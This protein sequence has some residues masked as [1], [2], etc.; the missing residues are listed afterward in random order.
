MWYIYTFI[1]IFLC[2]VVLYFLLKLGT[3]NENTNMNGYMNGYRNGEHFT[4]AMLPR[5]SNQVSKSILIPI[6]LMYMPKYIEIGETVFDTQYDYVIVKAFR[7]AY[8]RQPRREELLRYRRMFLSGEIDKEFLYIILY[9]TVEHSHHKDLQSDDVQ[10]GLEQSIWKK[11]LYVII[12]DLYTRYTKKD[13]TEKKNKLWIALKNILIHLR[14]NLYMFVAVLTDNNYNE[15]EREIMETEDVKMDEFR[16]YEIFYTYIDPMITQRLANA[17]KDSD[18]K[19]G[20]SSV[21]NGSLEDIEKMLEKERKKLMEE[22]LKNAEMKNAE[23]ANEDDKNNGGLGGLDEEGA[24]NTENVMIDPR[25]LL[26]DVHKL[27]QIKE[28]N[29]EHNVTAIWKVQGAQLD[30]LPGDEFGSI[31]KVYQPYPGRHEETTMNN[32]KNIDTMIKKDI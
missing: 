11:K 30:Q 7:E 14:F 32:T 31:S 20:G 1:V 10:V 15:M 3:G 12:R 24:S 26:I 19:N 29:L 8:D 21:I 27:K 2:L 25:A 9:N 23:E 4:S 5:N 16:L 13:M 22:R 28:G 17:M 6:P 18:R